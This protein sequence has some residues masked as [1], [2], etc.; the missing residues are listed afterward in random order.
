[1]LHEIDLSVGTGEHLLILGPNGCGKSTLLKTLTCELYPVPRPE[2][3]VN[4]FGRARWDVAE[5]RRRMGVVG[6]ELPGE[7][8]RGVTGLEAVLTGFFSSSKIWPNLSVT[9]VMR[10]RAAE[11]LTLV[12][13]EDLQDALVGEMSAGQQR[14]VMIGRGTGGVGGDVVAG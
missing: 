3:R 13:A 14:R 1:M 9:P 5:L 6:A 10:E 7:A 4:L 8:T 12:R 2:T 11:I